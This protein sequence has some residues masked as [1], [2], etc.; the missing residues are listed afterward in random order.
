VLLWVQL[1]LPVG[2]LDDPGEMSATVAVHV[3]TRPVLPALGE[4][5]TL[6]DVLRLATFT[7]ALPVLA[8]C[9]ESPRYEP[10]TLSGPDA[11]GVMLT[12]HDPLTSEHEP[13]GVKVTAPFGVL[14]VPDETSATM[15]E[16]DKATS[17][18]PDGG[19]VTVVEVL[20]KDPPTVNVYVIDFV[21]L[22]GRTVELL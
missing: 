11:V 5:M 12:E 15:A 7:V 21:Q 9:V 4:Q 3:E 14:A 8:L 10:E 19:H 13:P 2:V 20:R 6:I 1:T 18:V 22:R 17:T 16:H